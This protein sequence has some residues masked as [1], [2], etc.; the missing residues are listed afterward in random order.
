M[1]YRRA[2]I[3]EIDI[4]ANLRKQ[5][6]IDEGMA[7]SSDIDLELHNFFLR[8]MEDGNL[9]EWVAIDKEE[10][11]ATAA[12]IFYDFPPNFIN[13]SGVRGYIANVYTRPEYRGRGI[14][15]DLIDKLV[16]EARDRGVK[17]LWLGASKMGRP[18]YLKY[19]FV[20][21]DEYL[22]LNLH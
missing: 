10:I 5:Q 1:Y 12:I 11:I 4:L 17:K 3:N 9:I 2:T 19:G 15:T 8:N 13:K 14:A 21:T 16:E 7:P 18:V 20:E 22:E 6:L